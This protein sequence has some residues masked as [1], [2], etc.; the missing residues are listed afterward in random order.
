MVSPAVRLAAYC[1]KLYT[2][3]WCDT[4]SFSHILPF[5]DGPQYPTTLD[6]YDIE[7]SVEAYINL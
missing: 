5:R 2:H 7:N 4:F 3:F 1:F 6:N